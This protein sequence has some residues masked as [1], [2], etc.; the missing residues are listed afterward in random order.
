[1]DD[2]AKGLSG[3]S[4]N[5]DLPKLG[6]VGKVEVFWRVS[7]SIKVDLDSV[8]QVR[9]ADDKEYGDGYGHENRVCLFRRVAF[10][11]VLR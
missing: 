5:N 8:V 6:Q 11:G 9:H 7:H 1:M 10:W 4:S 2:E 3:T